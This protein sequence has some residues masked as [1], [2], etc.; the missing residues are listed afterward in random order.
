[1]IGSGAVGKNRAEHF[2]KR[3][4]SF[5]GQRAE[6]NIVRHTQDRRQFAKQAFAF[7][8][9]AEEHAAPV[10]LVRLFF[11]DALLDQVANFDRHEL[12]G[13]VKLLRQQADG[14]VLAF[15]LA[16]SILTGIMFGLAPALRA[17][18]V[19]LTDSLKEGGRSSSAGSRHRTRSIFVVAEV[20][21]ALVLLVSAGLMMNT[22]LRVLRASPGFRSDRVLTLDFRLT[23]TKY[24]DVTPMDKTGF[25]LVT[26]QVDIF[27]RQVLE[28]LKALRLARDGAAPPQPSAPKRKSAGRNKGKSGSLADWLDGEEKEGR[29]G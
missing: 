1:M 15:T 16:I 8:G 7:G 2:L 19:E 25:D 14:R 23:G 5:L 3:F 22:F 4:R 27:C 29:R 10:G 18:K 21:L 20:A 26:P 28:R 24:L 13:D 11:D 9:Q 17:S 12:T 6:V